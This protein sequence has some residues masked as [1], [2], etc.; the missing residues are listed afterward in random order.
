MQDHLFNGAY[1]G[2]NTAS[3][4]SA[5]NFIEVAKAFG[6]HSEKIQFENLSDLQ[7]LSRQLN[8]ILSNPK[9]GL[10]EITLPKTQSMKPRVRSKKT[11]DGKITSGSIDIMWPFLDD[12]ANMRIAEDLKSS[13]N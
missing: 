8:N 13:S 4:I 5:P 1:F 10:Y 2:S 6:I 7:I 3:G 9:S 11:E 12:A